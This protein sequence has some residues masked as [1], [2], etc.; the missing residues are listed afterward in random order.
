[1]LLACCLVYFSRNSVPSRGL[2]RA[3]LVDC[4]L[5]LLHCRMEVN[6]VDDRFLGDLIQDCRVYSEGSVKKATEVLYPL[7]IDI[8]L[9]GLTICRQDRSGVW[10]GRSILCIYSTKEHFIFCISKVIDLLSF[11]L[12]PII[13]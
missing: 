2:V 1:M 3:A 4:F 8:F 5:Y 10:H 11:P 12:P 7:I 13:M 9:Q 6:T